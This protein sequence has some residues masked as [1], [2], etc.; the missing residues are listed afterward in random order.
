MQI[1]FPCTK[2]GVKLEIDASS[3][4]SEVA[5]P[6]CQE[7]LQVP[8][9]QIGEGTTIG[10]FRIERMLGKGGMERFTWRGKSRWIV[11][12]RSRF[13]PRRCGTTRAPQ[14]GSCRRC[15]SWRGWGIRIL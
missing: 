5:C 13:S 1:T 10:G 11:R 2:C 3:A 14:N 6:Q 9:A 8:V 15:E 7:S 12:W 4:G